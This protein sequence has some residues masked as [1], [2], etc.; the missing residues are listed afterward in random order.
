MNKL[1][2][3]LAFCLLAFDANA[4]LVDSKVEYDAAT[5]LYTYTYRIGASVMPAGTI[6][7]NLLENVAFNFEG[8]LPVAHT[9][10]DGWSFR[11]A[12][13]GWGKAPVGTQGSFWSWANTSFIPSDE[14][15]NFSF[16]TA[17]APETSDRNN[18]VLWASNGQSGPGN[19]PNVID[20]GN[21]IGPQLVNIPQPPSPVP[22]PRAAAMLMFGMLLLGVYTLRQRYPAMSILRM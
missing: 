8:P 19:Y 6:E 9:E 1:L 15:L 10:P 20:F 11:L 22:E 21:V 3:F 12:V 18:L 16:T 4:D 13:G 14:V 17:Y 2:L 7:L 5:N